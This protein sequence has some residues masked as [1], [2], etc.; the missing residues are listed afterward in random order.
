LLQIGWDLLKD[1]TGGDFFQQGLSRWVA[2]MKAQ[3]GGHA[4]H[5][6]LHG[7]IIISTGVVIICILTRCCGSFRLGGGGQG[8]N[9]QGSQKNSTR[10]LRLE[11]WT[12]ALVVFLAKRMVLVPGEPMEQVIFRNPK[13]VCELLVIL[14]H[15][16]GLWGGQ[17]GIVLAAL[18]GDLQN[19][20]NIFDGAEAF[21]VQVQFT[22]SLQLCKS[23]LQME[24]NGFGGPAF[25]AANLTN[26]NSI[27]GNERYDVSLQ[28]IQY[29]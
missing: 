21:G 26:I 4:G 8:W 14:G 22:G 5:F 6:L 24:L 11:F 12:H 20:V 3:Q 16:F 17:I 13:Q 19:V 18:V 29:I 27:A 15:E 1:P 2:C 28:S 7:R 10:L 25:P 23:C 9:T